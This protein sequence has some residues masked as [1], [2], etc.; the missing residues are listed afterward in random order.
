MTFRFKMALKHSTLVASNNAIAE[1]W[2]GLTDLDET[3]SRCDAV[4]LY[5]YL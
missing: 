3:F 1:V 2:S 5:G 4:I